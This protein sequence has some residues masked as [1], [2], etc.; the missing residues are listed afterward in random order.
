MPHSTLHHLGI[1]FDIDGLDDVMYGF[2]AYRML[3]RAVIAEDRELFA[4]CR[5]WDGDTQE[6]LAGNARDYVIA[7][8]TERPEVPGAI[9]KLMASAESP[10]LKPVA[11]R[12][13][14]PE[15]IYGEPLVHA[16]SINALGV[17]ESCETSWVLTAWD[18]ETR[19]AQSVSGL[20][21]PAD[22]NAQRKPD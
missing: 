5:F 21:R 9:R 17:M 3:F 4:G 2:K 8:G 16:A 6:T 13:L 12:F 19:A 14:R 22:R 11:R 18:I 15:D 7:L 10:G 20:A 1:A